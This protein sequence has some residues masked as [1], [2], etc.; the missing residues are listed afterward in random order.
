MLTDAG[1]ALVHQPGQ[2]RQV[3][4]LLLVVNLG[5]LLRPCS[6]RDWNAR[7][8]PAADAGIDDCGDISR[9]REISLAEC[10]GN[11]LPGVASGQLCGVQGAPLRLVTVLR[12]AAG[13]EVLG[14]DLPVAPP[15]AGVVSAV[16][17]ACRMPRWSAPTPAG[18]RPLGAH[19]PVL[20][21]LYSM[22]CRVTPNVVSGA[23]KIE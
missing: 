2:L 10:L 3:R 12:L 17:I 5:N 16:Q 14:E 7:A 18:V 11:D 9:A 8:F 19:A 4:L 6:L 22:R 1:L 15:W 20:R 23:V 21:P 13:R